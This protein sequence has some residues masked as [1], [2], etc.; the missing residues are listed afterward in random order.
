MDS[1]VTKLLVKDGSTNLGSTQLFDAWSF[2]FETN[3]WASKSFSGPTPNSSLAAATSLPTGEACVWGGSLNPDVLYILDTNFT[4]WSELST[5]SSFPAI[6]GH[7]LSYDANSLLFLVYGGISNSSTFSAHL[8]ALHET[9]GAKWKQL[10]D[11]STP[12]SPGPL[13]FHTAVVIQ[14]SLWI[15]GGG[16]EDNGTRV[17]SNQVL[18]Y[19]I[20]DNAWE[21]ISVTGPSPQARWQHSAVVSLDGYWFVFGGEGETGL[22]NDLWSFDFVTRTWQQ[23][24]INAPGLPDR[25]NGIRG[26]SAVVWLDLDKED[27]MV[28]F[29]GFTDGSESNK[30]WIYGPLSQ[31]SSD[32]SHDGD[33]TQ[34]ELGLII[35]AYICCVFV[36]LFVVF[37][38][39]FVLVWKQ[40][41]KR[42][43]RSVVVDHGEEVNKTS[44][45]TH[46][47]SNIS[48]DSMPIQN[49][50][51]EEELESSE[52]SESES[53]SECS[54]CTTD[55]ENCDAC[56]QEKYD[57]SPTNPEC[58]V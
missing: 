15:F 46:S 20:T 54:E 32:K 33:L 28:L 45:S 13:A 12:N 18:V 24:E 27:F 51:N 44:L 35:G 49:S 17:F 19:S 10:T 23:L 38:L 42:N 4:H 34:A 5:P 57:G 21:S 58:P 6:E 29:G 7:T 22:L 9:F 43:S 48:L 36:L 37:L 16:Y 2:D 3:Y 30:L 53:E 39:L 26:Q 14:D 8:Y 11:D 47:D 1:S 40:L 52:E 55:E 56:N 41:R 25:P 50:A 31:S